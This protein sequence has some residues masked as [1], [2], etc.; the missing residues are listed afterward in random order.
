MLFLFFYGRNSG[1]LCQWTNLKHWGHLTQ[2]PGLRWV[3]NNLALLDCF[4]CCCCWCF[5]V[6]LFFCAVSRTNAH[7]LK[8]KS[9][10]SEEMKSGSPNLVYRVSLLSTQV[11]RLKFSLIKHTGRNHQGENALV[12]QQILPTSVIG[13]TRRQWGKKAYW[14]WGL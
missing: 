6:C 3:L 5:F 12:L 1:H 9:G 10:P 2:S 7:V 8:G 4:C 13:S 14:Y 11:A